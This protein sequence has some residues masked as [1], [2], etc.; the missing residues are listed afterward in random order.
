MRRDEAVERW[1]STKIKAPGYYSRS[2]S[3]SASGFKA[4]FFLGSSFNL[5]GHLSPTLADN[6]IFIPD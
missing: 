6:K 5:Q 3:L 1:R 4:T 2:W